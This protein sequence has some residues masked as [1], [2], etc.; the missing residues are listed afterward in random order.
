VSCQ[1]HFDEKD[2][3]NIDALA[4]KRCKALLS[5]DDAYAG[6]LDAL[7]ELKVADKTYVLVTSDHGSLRIK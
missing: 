5:V 6:I 2:K 3:G 4:A 1:P 7:D